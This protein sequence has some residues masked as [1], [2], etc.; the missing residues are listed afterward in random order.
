MPKIFVLHERKMRFVPFPGTGEPFS[1][2]CLGVRPQK[3]IEKLEYVRVGEN[4][5]FLLRRK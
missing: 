5:Y 1:S 4:V 3:C 2:S